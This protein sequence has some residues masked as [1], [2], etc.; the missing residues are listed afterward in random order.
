MGVTLCVSLLMHSVSQSVLHCVLHWVSYCVTVWHSVDA[1]WCI[2]G[3]FKAVQS[4]RTALLS[5]ALHFTLPS[6]LYLSLPELLY[7]MQLQLSSQH[8]TA[9]PHEV[10]MTAQQSAQERN[11]DWSAQGAYGTKNQIAEMSSGKLVVR[12]KPKT[13]LKF[14]CKSNVGRVNVDGSA[15]SFE[16]IAGCDADDDHHHRHRCHHHH[17][18]HYHHPHHHHHVC[19][20]ECASCEISGGFCEDPTITPRQT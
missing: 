16:V 17:L 7:S 9:K 12:V 18:H 13:Y 4:W 19:W 11:L 14:F 10:E 5:G 8:K 15:A 6:C 1:L 20:W 2:A 3:S